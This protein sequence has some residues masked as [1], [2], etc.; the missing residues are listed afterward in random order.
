MKLRL[1]KPIYHNGEVRTEG[2]VIETLVQHGRE[3]EKKGYAKGI[4]EDTPAEQPEQP[5]QPEQSKPSKTKSK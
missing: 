1:I 2:A 5:E 3:L 4:A